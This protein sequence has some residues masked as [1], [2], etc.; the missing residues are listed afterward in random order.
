M[1]TISTVGYGDVAP[2]PALRTFT[3]FY[4][5]VGVLFIFRDMGKGLEVIMAALEYYVTAGT[6]CLLRVIRVDDLTREDDDDR[7]WHVER[8]GLSDVAMIVGTLVLDD[9]GSGRRSAKCAVRL[10]CEHA[11]V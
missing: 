8:V 2:P 11:C 1:V 9:C 3:A 10:V 7:S 6:S 4:I 5:L